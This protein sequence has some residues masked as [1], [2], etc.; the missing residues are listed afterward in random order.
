MTVVNSIDEF[1]VELLLRMFEPHTAS[2]HLAKY[3]RYVIGCSGIVF[4][5]VIIM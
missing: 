5:H 1:V 3:C 2:T 4:G